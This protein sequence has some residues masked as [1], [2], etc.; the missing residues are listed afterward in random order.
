MSHSLCRL[1]A[2]R[3]RMVVATHCY[4]STGRKELFV[5]HALLLLPEHLHDY[6]SEVVGHVVSIAGSAMLT[7]QHMCNGGTQILGPIVSDNKLTHQ[8]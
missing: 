7:M 4:T 6:I 5:A 3:E 8:V 2:L 1:Q